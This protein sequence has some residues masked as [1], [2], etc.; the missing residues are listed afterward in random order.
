MFSQKYRLQKT[1]FHSVCCLEVRNE[2]MFSFNFEFNISGISIFQ[3]W[4]WHEWQVTFSLVSLFSLSV[5]V[6][7]SFC[8]CFGLCLPVS[9]S[10]TFF[11]VVLM[12]FCHIPF[13]GKSLRRTWPQWSPG[14]PASVPLYFYKKKIKL[15]HKMSQCNPSSRILS[16]KQV[17]TARHS[18]AAAAHPSTSLKQCKIS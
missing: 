11:S 16:R 17:P 12:I 13:H 1:K 14:K 5:F 10:H 15:M 2:F 9:V 7:L 18:V 4:H 8:L 3:S 6:C